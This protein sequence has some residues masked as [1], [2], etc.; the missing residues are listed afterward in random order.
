MN[1]GA[2]AVQLCHSCVEGL[3]YTIHT[4]DFPV[5]SLVAKSSD[6]NSG[7]NDVQQ[8]QR[9]AHTFKQHGT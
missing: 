3:C 8:Q 2:S 4:A 1:E 7:V 6:L 5:V 9:Q